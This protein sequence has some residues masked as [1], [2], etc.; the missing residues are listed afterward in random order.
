MANSSP[1]EVVVVDGLLRDDKVRQP[2][3]DDGEDEHLE[4]GDEIG[5]PVEDTQTVPAIAV[6]T[7]K[8]DRQSTVQQGTDE[9][10]DEGVV[11]SVQRVKVDVLG[12]DEALQRAALAGAAVRSTVA[13]T[14]EDHLRRLKKGAENGDGDEEEKQLTNLKWVL[15]D[16]G[17]V[18]VAT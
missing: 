14:G 6:F 2:G 13:A 16:E 1:V 8:N 5:G 11:L 3:D 17:D 4:E 18:G 9:H 7:A 10:D 15:G 12:E